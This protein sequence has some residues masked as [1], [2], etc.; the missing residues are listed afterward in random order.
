MKNIRLALLRIAATLV[1]G[2]AIGCGDLDVEPTPEELFVSPSP[3]VL[4]VGDS[5]RLSLLP[6]STTPIAA[7]SD[8]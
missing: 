2:T 1:S 4:L 3:V 7:V 6:A 5:V 8:G